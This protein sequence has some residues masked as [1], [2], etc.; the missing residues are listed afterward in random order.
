MPGK[1]EKE[2]YVVEISAAVKARPVEA[3]GIT[4][5]EAVRVWT[6]VALLSFGGPAGQIATMHRILVGRNVG[7]P[8]RG[9]C[10]P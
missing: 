6:R 5:A 3:H 2:V 7:F 9:F 4:L 10:M 8:K 1:P